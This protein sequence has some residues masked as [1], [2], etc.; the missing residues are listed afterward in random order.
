MGL[1]P[2]G[3]CLSFQDQDVQ[4]NGSW[5]WNLL[6]QQASNKEP[7]S[8]EAEMF[9]RGLLWDLPGVQ[10]LRIPLRISLLSS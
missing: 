9:E 4:M 2:P 5:L 10:H 3:A 1:S 7:R 8:R 6:D